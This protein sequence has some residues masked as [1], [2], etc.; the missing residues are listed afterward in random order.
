[1]VDIIKTI[2]ISFAMIVTDDTNIGMI[3]SKKSQQY[4]GIACLLHR[5]DYIFNCDTRSKSLANCIKA[6]I[7]FALPF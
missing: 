1:M 5:S 4:S 2:G 7:L 3:V 6:H